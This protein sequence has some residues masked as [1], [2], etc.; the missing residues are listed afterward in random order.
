MVEYSHDE[1]IQLLSNN[2][3]QGKKSL[4]KAEAD[5]E[6]MKDQITVAEVSILHYFSSNSGNIFKHFSLTLYHI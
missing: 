2:L 5:L 6:Y 3:A 1:A 4:E